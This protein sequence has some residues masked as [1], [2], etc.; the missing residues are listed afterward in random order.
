M[1]KVESL[2]YNTIF[3]KAFR[4]VEL[5][6]GLVKDFTG[7]QLQI[8]KVENDKIFFPA[9]G[10]VEIRFDLFAEDKKNRVI[11]EA[12]HANRSDNFERFLYYHCVAMVETIPNS[13]NYR[14]PITV[15]TLVFFTN[16]YSPSPGNNVLIHDFEIRN[17]KNKKVVKDVYGHQHQLFFVFTSNPLGDFDIPE[18]CREW[19]QAIDDSLDEQAD[20]EDYD[21]PLIQRLFKTI[22]KDST[23]PAERARM[24]EEYNQYLDSKQAFEMGQLEKGQS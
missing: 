22:S 6:T 1:I 5:F 8:D 15:I 17:W 4:D 2:Q 11:V 3:K 16:R 7:I 14:F 18:T 19:I 9:V 21:N 10:E 23:T 12:Q 24:K 13:K 20:E